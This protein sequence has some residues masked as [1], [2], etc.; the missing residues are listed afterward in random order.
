MLETVADSLK[1]TLEGTGLFNVVEQGFSRRAL[2]SPPSAVF[3]MAED[4][5]VTDSPY[6]T[7]KLSW[8][9]ALMV[10]YIDPVKAHEKMNTII[11]EL[12]ETLSEWRPTERGS[13]PSTV[14]RIDFE[15]VEDTLLI[16]SARVAMQVVPANI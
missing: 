12:R 8:D 13:L 2:S 1:A 7:R 6:I 4:G 16:Y 5:R 9:I 10:S 11:D 15:V 14:E 3:F